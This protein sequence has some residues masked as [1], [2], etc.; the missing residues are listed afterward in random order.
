VLVTGAT[1]FL[2]GHTVR[3]LLA[4]GAYVK[5]LGRNPDKAQDLIA[6]GADFYPVDIWWDPAPIKNL[7]RD[8]DTVIH[9]GG[10]TTVWANKTQFY[11]VNTLGTRNVV[12]ACLNARVQRMIHLSSSSI[13]CNGGDRL[14]IQEKDTLPRRF[15]NTYAWSKFLAD[16]HVQYGMAQGLS[17]IVLRPKGVFGPGENTLLPRLL[18]A[19]QR[20]G[21]PLIKDGQAL[22]DTTYLDNVID[23][24]E[25]AM[26]APQE[27]CGQVFNISNAQP[28]AVVDL[29]KQL[30]DAIDYPLR[31]KHMPY[32]WAL[33][34]AY[35]EEARARLTQHEPKFNRF[36]LEWLAYSQTL[37]IEKARHWLGYNPAV[38]V[39]DGIQ[40]YAHHWL[41]TQHT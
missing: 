9:C 33:T 24:I 28:M 31:L 15:I 10:L 8:V 2:G 30:F 17:A 37:A 1:G 32:P 29:L 13:Y 26:A 21:I 22:I 4:R 41:Q 40:R 38:S 34:L 23:A 19:N 20:G 16:Q 25:L 12:A 3:R 35:V 18:E 36:M 7:C 11:Q 6:L 27:A 39:S 14:N 5:A